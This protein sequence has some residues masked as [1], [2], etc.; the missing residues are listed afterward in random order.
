MHPP[1]DVLGFAAAVCVLA[2]FCMRS[3][4]SLRMLALVSNIL[5]MAYAYRIGLLPVLLLHT[6]LLPINMAYL[7]CTPC[8]RSRQIR[9]NGRPQGVAD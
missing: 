5:F 7:F 3:M 4:R 2:T 9:S 8:G 1:D 6:V